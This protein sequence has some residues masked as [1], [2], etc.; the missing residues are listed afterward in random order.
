MKDGGDVVVAIDHY[1]C[2]ACGLVLPSAE[3]DRI[4]AC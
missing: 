2:G 1:Q 3:V 4:G